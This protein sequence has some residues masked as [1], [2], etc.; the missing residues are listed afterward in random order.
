LFFFN[1]NFVEGGS[2]ARA[3]PAG[4]FGY[5]KVQLG[6]LIKEYTLPQVFQ[7]GVYRLGDVLVGSVPVE[8]TTEVGALIRETILG[9][10]PAGVDRARGQL[11]ERLRK[12][13]CQRLRIRSTILRGGFDLVLAQ[14]RGNTRR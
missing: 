12:L 11:G 10:G 2:A 6:V 14:Y 1:L 3:T 8:R 13:R 7:F 9:S 5:K 4:C